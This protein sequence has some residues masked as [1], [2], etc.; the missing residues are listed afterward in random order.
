MCPPPRKSLV[1]GERF[2][3]SEGRPEWDNQL[4]QKQRTLYNYS[5]LVF[6]GLTLECQTTHD[7]IVAVNIIIITG[8]QFDLGVD[9]R[10]DDLTGKVRELEKQNTALKSKVS[11]TVFKICT[12]LLSIILMYTEHCIETT[13]GDKGKETFS[14]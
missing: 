1:K 12:C 7:V 5:P 2:I 6:V 13:A 9:E 10:L 3:R 14:L 11:D 4:A 8:R